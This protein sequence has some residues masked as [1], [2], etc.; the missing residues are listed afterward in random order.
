MNHQDTRLDYD[1]VVIGAGFSGLR[2]VHEA[3]ER[4]LSVRV[5]EAGHDVGGTWNFNRY[6]GA[7]TDSES[8]AY[9]FS[10][11]KQL[12]DDWNWQ[13]RY[14][15]QPQVLDYLRHV[16]ERF[17]MR[18]DIQF[19]TRVRAAEFDSDRDQWTVTTEQGETIVCQFLISASGLLSVPSEPPF[20]GLADFQGEWHMTAR[21]PHEGV[22]WADK[23]VAVIGTG[24]SAIQLIPIVAETAS[25]LT[26]FQ[27]TA[28][29]VLPARNYVLHD[30]QRQRIKRDYD[31]VW[32]QVSRHALG[33]PMNPAGRIFDDVTPQERQRILDAGWEEG[34]FRY[35]A[36]T[37]D[38]V[39]VN[40]E[41]NA[42]VS[43]FARNKIR[44]VVKDPKTAE[45]LCPLENHPLGAKRP[46]LGHYYYE[47]FNRDNVELVG[48]K[49]NAIDD[50]TATGVRLADGTEYEA[51]LIIFAMGFDAATGSQT[52]IDIRGRNGATI[53]SKWATGPRTHLAL[54]VDDLPNFFLIFGPQ[55]P[56]ANAPAMIEPSAQ[57]VGRAITHTR[58]QGCT[59]IEPTV[60]AVEEYQREVITNYR[61]TIFPAGEAIGSWFVGANIAGKAVAPALNF[62]SFPN[63][64]AAMA[65][66]ADEGFQ[67]YRFSTSDALTGSKA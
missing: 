14:P 38:D 40:D 33:M 37:F 28:N 29:Y 25:R 17:D 52:S 27:R 3:R 51:D 2:M 43:E 22:D 45:L 44:T 57:W 53:A 10:F 32:D 64:I 15:T 35:F 47:T 4:G 9:C 41:A 13:E 54:T 16:A 20:P 12:Q 50:I 56:F 24:A 46:P 65:A 5:L 31:Q 1:I 11:D 8:W 42:A 30:A 23:R 21:W 63:C 39:F 36:E 26:V 66:E 59:R 48:V 6:P 60:E 7:R 19:G 34:G 61:S 62:D 18:R 67:H 49:D 55:I 58:E